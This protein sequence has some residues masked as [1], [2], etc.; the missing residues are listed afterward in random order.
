MTLAF[1]YS[2]EDWRAIE[3]CLEKLGAD[4]SDAHVRTYWRHTIETIVH[5]YLWMAERTDPRSLEVV[6]AK[7]CWRKLAVHLQ[8]AL[9]ALADLEAI[10]TQPIRTLGYAITRDPLNP[11]DD[12]LAWRAQTAAAGRWAKTADR[13]WPKSIRW[14]RDASGRVIGTKV[15]PNRSRGDDVDKLLGALLTFW[16]DCGGRVG[17]GSNSPST[18]FVM[19]A[20]G[21]V[22]PAAIGV[23]LPRAIVDFVRDRQFD[24]A[25]RIWA[26]QRDA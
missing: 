24:E 10:E 17:K 20:I 9:G 2:D 25:R 7:A 18:R 14:K 16:V 6:A 12:Y 4:R 23:K 21:R 19:A 13:G 8:G 5:S 11:H 26:L 22:L 1:R 15:G 3:V